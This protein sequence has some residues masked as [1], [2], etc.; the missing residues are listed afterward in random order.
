MARLWPA[1][2]A[3]VVVCNVLFILTHQRYP[4]FASFAALTYTT[5]YAAVIYGHHL[6][7]YGPTW[8]LA[9]EEHFY[10]IWPLVA[11]YCLRR[12]ALRGLLRGALLL[13]VG[14]L[15]WRAVLLFL[16]APSRLFYIG[17]FERADAL[18]FGCAAAVAVRLGWRPGRWA[19]PLGL[20]LIVLHLTGNVLN[21]ALLNSTVLGIGGALVC[22]G[23]DC[24]APRFVRRALS[25]RPV[26]WMGVMS[27]G[28]YLWHGPLITIREAAGLTR[29]WNA[30]S[31]FAA[32]VLA[33]FSHRYLERPVRQWARGVD[34]ANIPV[35][36][37]LV[38]G[39]R[40][41]LRRIGQRQSVPDETAPLIVEARQPSD[42]APTQRP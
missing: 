20:T 31:V 41:A 42:P 28:I 35:R 1:L 5:N 29:E 36:V 25:L 34:I 37:A 21:T 7:G 26:V 12:W 9:V 33:A 19:L 27:Y 30:L 24:S 4:V 2:L 16:D 39:A 40:A 10:L 18:L 11:I 38:D 13:C 22:V 14:A 15:A 8:S 17:S 32:F 6:P 23:L 3:M